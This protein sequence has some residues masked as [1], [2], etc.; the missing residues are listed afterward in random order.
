MTIAKAY[1]EQTDLLHL[2][3]D[4]L[5]TMYD[6]PS[7][8]PQ[9]PGLPDDFHVLQPRLL[10]DTFRP[11]HYS[12]ERIY[13]ATDLNL[14]YDLQHP[15]WQK[16]PDWFAV[17]GVPQFYEEEE[18][19]LSYV[20]WQEKVSPTVI[21]EL[22]SPGT[23]KEDLG[24]SQRS[25]QQPPTKWDVYEKILKVPYYLVFDRYTDRLRAFHLR[26]ATYTSLPLPQDGRIWMPEVGLG[27]G[28]W[29][30][31][32]RGRQRLWLR[33][34]NEQ[35]QWI[36][37]DAEQANLQTEQ[38]RQRTEQERQRAKQERQRAKQE[39][40]RA[41]QER[42]HAEQERQHAEQERQRAEQERQRAEQ[43]RQRAESAEQEVHRLA[44]KLKALGINPDEF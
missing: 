11:P 20:I 9:E 29:E 8:D 28:L 26:D 21:V 31:R 39:R 30:G 16:R 41:K 12:V 43:E 34:Y 37:T 5:P 2:P 10:D 36:A 6:L 40:Q 7:E 19:R 32:Y 24:Q 27:L 44:E 13:T 3:Q 38:E 17:L 33:W 4:A 25:A 35:G 18:L 15:L 22:L 23:E 14:Y 1:I 42:Q